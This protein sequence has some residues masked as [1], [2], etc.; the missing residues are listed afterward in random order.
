M[1]SGNLVY[2][3]QLGPCNIDDAAQK[4]LVV[5]P[6]PKDPRVLIAQNVSGID[7]ILTKPDGVRHILKSGGAMKL[8]S[9]TCV[10]GFD[11]SIKVL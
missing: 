2:R 1:V 7:L 5:R 11:G 4:I 8:E 3:C 10:D 9:G 6:H